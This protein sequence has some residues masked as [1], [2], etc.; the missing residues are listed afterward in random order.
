M[1][2]SLYKINLLLHFV[3]TMRTHTFF[4][5]IERVDCFQFGSIEETLIIISVMRRKIPR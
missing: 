2:F 1:M 5:L 3:T 4:F